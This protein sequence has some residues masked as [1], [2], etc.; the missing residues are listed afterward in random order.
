[1]TRCWPPDPLAG[2]HRPL[3]LLRQNPR[4]YPL[5]VRSHGVLSRAEQAAN[6]DHVC[7]LYDAGESIA[8]AAQGYFRAGLTRGDR[9]MWVGDDFA[10]RV[11]LP[12]ADTLVAEGALQLLPQSPSYEARQRF[13]GAEQYA[14]YDAATRQ[15]RAEGYT[16]LCVV[17]EVTATTADPDRCAE[18]IRWEHLADRFIAGG[19][20]MTAMCLYENDAL[21]AETAAELATVHAWTRAS[22]GEPPFRVWFDGA[23]LCLTGS[24]DTFNA[25]RLES[26]LATTPSDD[27]AV[28][29]DLTELE[30][31]DAAATRTLA[32]W[33]LG[34]RRRDMPVRLE[35]TP[36][37]LRKIWLLLGYET[38]VFAPAPG[39]AG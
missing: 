16:G 11:G 17:A 8:E 24:V 10:H 13:A 35:G 33:A 37:F 34:L 28:V 23:R 1:M 29:L 3:R 4:P 15:A 32:R 5:I 31:A 30:F 27:G 6:L 9:L 22:G 21:R 18:L 39:H 2:A 12:G 25:A 26:V 14:F 38:D 7:W 20:G 36:R 19:S